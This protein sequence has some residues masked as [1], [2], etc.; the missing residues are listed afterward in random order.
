ME[1]VTKVFQL[2]KIGSIDWI[3][4]KGP[5]EAKELMIEIF[6]DEAQELLDH[7]ALKVI[8]LSENEIN[9][10]VFTD[11]KGKETRAVDK[12]AQ[13]TYEELPVHLGSST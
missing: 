5:E 8:E 10:L 3:A 13:I 4:A 11:E 1:L 7:D 9:R 2:E 12:L 6:E